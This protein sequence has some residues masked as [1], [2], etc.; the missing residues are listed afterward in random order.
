METPEKLPGPDLARDGA[1][2]KDFANDLLEGHFEGVPVL[3]VRKGSRPSGLAPRE[4][5]T[6]FTWSL[7]VS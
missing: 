5:Q 7:R 1:A 3:L 2:L 4:S 6:R